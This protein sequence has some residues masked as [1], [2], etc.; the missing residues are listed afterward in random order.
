MSQEWSE[1]AHYYDYF[2]QFTKQ[3]AVRTVDLVE[4]EIEKERFTGQ[5]NILDVAC[6][7]GNVSL[8]FLKR[9]PQKVNVLAVDLSE[10]MVNIAEQK[11]LA[12]NAANASV[13]VMDGQVRY[14]LNLF[15]LFILFL[16]G[17]FP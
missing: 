17:S 7:T 10:Q 14:F 3:F 15:N 2:G 13:K 4:N 6:G 8:A 12:L 11:I 1:A 5:I 16:A 9:M